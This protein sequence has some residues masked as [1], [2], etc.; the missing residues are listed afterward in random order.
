MPGEIM[1]LKVAPMYLLKTC[2][3]SYTISYL[4]VLS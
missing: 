3:I 4:T 1:V 2:I